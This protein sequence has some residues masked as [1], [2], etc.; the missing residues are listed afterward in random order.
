MKR[1]YIITGGVVVILLLVAIWVYLLLNGNAR[2]GADLFANLGFDF[3]SHPANVVADPTSDEPS[4]T[5]DVNQ[6]KL[7]Q[8]TTRPVAGFI[9]TSVASSS[10]VRYVEQGTGHIYEINLYTGTEEIISR[11]TIPKVQSAEFSPD[12]LV[13]AITAINGYT[14]DTFF[15]RI[16][17]LKDTLE[18]IS[19]P[20]RADNLSVTENGTARYTLVQNEELVG[21]EH[22]LGNEL[23]V[24]FRVPFHLIKVNWTPEQIRFFNRPA[25]TMLGYLYE[26]KSGSFTGTPLNG[27]GLNVDD[28]GNYQGYTKTVDG[29]LET[30]F[31]SLETNEYYTSPILIVPEKCT[32]VG[33][34][35]EII[36]AAPTTK[37]LDVYDWYKGVV[38]SEDLLWRMDPELSSATLIESL[39]LTAGRP[40]DVTF[41]QS[42]TD[43]TYL[44]FVNKFDGTL[45]R[46]NI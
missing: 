30:G 36:C 44:L 35:N 33:S 39:D 43:G 46:Y 19:L 21:Y 27:F 28:L 17:S 31:Y 2:T 26:V 34:A 42:S 37:S 24:L 40:V 23:S 20:P 13:V 9:G 16:D 6:E 11:T 18:G 5:V 32:A 15:S 41:L 38:N 1:S 22:T 14:K 4:Y 10:V 45:W 8:L 12:G 29:E 25:E 7:E 3:E